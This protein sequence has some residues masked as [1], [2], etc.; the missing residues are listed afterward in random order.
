V[1][2]DGRVMIWFEFSA[3]VARSTWRR[4]DRANEKKRSLWNGIG[5]FNS[6]HESGRVRIRCLM[7]ATQHWQYRS[8][9]VSSCKCSR[10]YS[11]LQ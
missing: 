6:G 11:Y 1:I 5:C 10:N 8:N 3:G 9:L 4:D 7:S 2:T